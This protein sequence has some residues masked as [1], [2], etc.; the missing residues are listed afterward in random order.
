MNNLTAALILVALAL[1]FACRRFTRTTLRDIPG[2]KPVSFW[3][4]NLEQYFLGQAGEGDFHLQERY[5]RIARLHGSIG[6]EYLWISDP[7]ALRYIFQTS[8]YRY[9]KQPERRA[10][11][12]LHSGHGLVWADGEVHKR[13]RKVMLPAFGAPESK[14]LLPH[15]ARAAEAVSVK[16]KDILTTAPSLSKELNVSTWLSRATMDAIGE[17]AFDYHFGALENTDT[18][19]VR[20][21]NNLMPIVF[22]A[23]TADAIFKRDALRIFRS[24][25]IVEWIYDRQRNPAVEKARECEEL[26]LK[27]AREL[28]ENKAEALE[29]GK[30][31]KDIFSLLVKANMTEDAK[32]RLSEEEMYAEMRTIL[33]AGHETTSTTISW[34]L[35]ELARHLPVQERLREEILAH[36]RGGELSATDLDGMPFLQAVVREAL[37]LH[38]VLNQTFRQAE[39]NDV[40]PLAHPLTDRTGTVLTALPI[41]KGTRVILSI[42]AYN[43]DTELWGSDAHAFDPD[44]WLDGRVKKVQTLGMYGNLLTFAAGVRGCIGW[45][46]AVY[47]IQTFLVE[48][49][50][51]FEFRPTEDLKRLRREP[52]GVMVPTLEG[53]RGTV[54]LPLRVSLL[55][56][57]I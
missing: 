18:D 27:I 52:C 43:R 23:P 26:T 21:Y 55:D 50:A 3:L 12:R 24:S 30:G 44:R 11:S 13:Q 54:Q 14:A 37:R 19:I 42:A 38:P 32:S 7:N 22:G 45:R 25:R 16:W 56:H 48:L 36:K 51:N 20:A 47:E 57:K 41:S 34:V 2:P 29:Q 4:G 35:L 39:Q 10:L 46:F 5:G 17:A 53:D 40:L 15:F 1:W 6:G 49:L 8:G 31:S 28:V 33:F 9:A